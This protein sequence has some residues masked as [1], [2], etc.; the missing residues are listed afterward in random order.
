MC[1]IADWYI[2]RYYAVNISYK[3]RFLGHVSAVYTLN[4]SVSHAS[5]IICYTIA[6]QMAARST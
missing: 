1:G 2:T 5:D 3:E 6:M 4:Q